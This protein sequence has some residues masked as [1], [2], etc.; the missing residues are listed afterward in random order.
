LG[1]RAD[2]IQ[3][4]VTIA[5]SHGY[6]EY[7]RL[8]QQQQQ[9]HQ[10]GIIT[11]A[12][13]EP[14]SPIAIQLACPYAVPAA[15]APSAAAPSAASLKVKHSRSSK[16]KGRFIIKPSDSDDP[17]AVKVSVTDLSPDFKPVATNVFHVLGYSTRNVVLAR[18]GGDG[19]VRADIANIDML[20]PKTVK[21]MKSATSKKGAGQKLATEVCAFTEDDFLECN[22][23]VP[24]GS[25]PGYVCTKDGPLFGKTCDHEMMESLVLMVTYSRRSSCGSY[26]FHV[27][28][29][30]LAIGDP[31]FFLPLPQVNWLH[32]NRGRCRETN[33]DRLSECLLHPSARRAFGNQPVRYVGSAKLVAGMMTASPSLLGDC[34]EALELMRL[35]VGAPV[36]R[37]LGNFIVCTNQKSVP[38]DKAILCLCHVELFGGE[39]AA[40]VKRLDCNRCRKS[41]TPDAKSGGK[42]RSS[43]GGGGKKAKA[44]KKKN[45]RATVL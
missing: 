26:L 1:R 42:K 22:L 21:E 37:K 3:V 33:T 11:P 41:A 32:P 44:T 14:P 45:E 17:R 10:H 18:M 43:S 8:Q 28:S 31:T 19:T 16:K 27:L 23:N 6:L 30:V 35:V 40:L 24:G 12:I 15:A 5:M 25:I 4:A 36:T 20:P 38:W 34:K 29:E 39:E 7:L 13:P 9:Q 2:V